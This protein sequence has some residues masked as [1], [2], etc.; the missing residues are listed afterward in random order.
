MLSA[1]LGA[2]SRAERRPRAGRSGHRRWRAV[3]RR[4]PDASRRAAQAAHPPARAA[5][6]QYPA[7]HRPAG[8]PLRDQPLCRQWLHRLPPRKSWIS[9][10]AT[11]NQAAAAAG[12]PPSNDVKI[13]DDALII[14]AVRNIVLFPGVVAP[15]TINRP[16]SIAAAQEALRDQRPTGILL[17]RD[18]E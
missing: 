16:K 1:A 9:Y 17:Q 10:M 2:L 12:A 7:P 15:I 13:P 6:G 14:V 4:Q 18:G 8:R 3:D 11:D 5:A